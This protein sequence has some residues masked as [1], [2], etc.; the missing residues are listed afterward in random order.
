LSSAT[1]LELCGGDM[2]E[3]SNLEGLQRDD[4]MLQVIDEDD[5]DLLDELTF[6]DEDEYYD[7]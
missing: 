6:E 5:E 7:D 3:I 2:E 1:V 4:I